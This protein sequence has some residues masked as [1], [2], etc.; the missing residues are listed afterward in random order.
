MP[1]KHFL[2]LHPLRAVLWLS[3]VLAD[4]VDQLMRKLASAVAHHHKCS[5]RLGP[6][7]L[8]PSAVGAICK[9]SHSTD[10]V[11]MAVTD[12]AMAAFEGKKDDG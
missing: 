3:L 7:L 4:K 5:D 12:L 10:E 9:A 6:W 8:K 11:A 2:V 1:E